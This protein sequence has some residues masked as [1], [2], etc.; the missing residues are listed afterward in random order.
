MTKE[1]KPWVTVASKKIVETRIFDLY[2]SQK[3]HPVTQSQHDFYSISST[4]WVNVIPVTI[5]HKVVMVRQFRHGIGDFCLEIPGGLVDGDEEH[6]ENAAKRELLEE[7]GHQAE[8]IIAL[9]SCYPNPAVQNNR[10]YFYLAKNCR[11]VATQN[12]DPTEDIEVV[13]I[14][15]EDIPK[16]INDGTIPHAIVVAAFAHFFLSSYRKDYK[17]NF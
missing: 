14:P 16:L 7:T 3:I 9:G 4:S 10:C 12:L 2:V 15:I 1:L 11:E 13:L 6:P 8:E 5:D 17:I